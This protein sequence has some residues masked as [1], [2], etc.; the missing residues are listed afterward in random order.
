MAYNGFMSGKPGPPDDSEESEE[1]YRRR[2]RWDF[3]SWRFIGILLA[4]G[5]LGLAVILKILGA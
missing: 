4:V 2:E 1:D 5:F 3:E